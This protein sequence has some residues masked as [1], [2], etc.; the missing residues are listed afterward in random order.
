MSLAFF[1]MRSSRHLAPILFAVA[2]AAPAPALQ[3]PVAPITATG[4]VQYAFTPGDRADNMI[5]D[6][7]DRAKKQLLVQ[8]FSFTHRRIAEALI[9]ANNRGVEVVVIADHQQTY[10]IDTSVI[11]KLAGAGVPVLLDPEHVSAHNKIMIIDAD[12]PDCAVIT[13]SYNFTHAAQYKNAENVLMVRDNPPLCAAY[14]RNWN[15]H[16]SHSRPFAR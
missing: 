4:S 6:A 1:R 8:A 5:I 12:S 14:R 7:I 9:K 10:Q 15:R 13:G 2:L 11:G 16:K 3:P